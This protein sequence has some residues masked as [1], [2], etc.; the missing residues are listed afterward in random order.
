MQKVAILYDVS[1]AVLSTFDLDEVLSQIL[2]I[3][4]DYF[5]VENC[6]ILLLDPS[7]QKLKV[8]KEFGRTRLDLEIPMGKGIIGSAAKRKLPIYAPDVSKDARYIKTFAETRSELAIPLVVRDEVYGVLDFQSTKLDYFDTDTIDLLTLFS[9]QASI[10]LANARHYSKEQR[11]RRQLEAINAI[12]EQIS[13]TSELDDLLEKICSLIPEKFAVEHAALILREGELDE[14][15]LV[16]RAHAGRLTP[17]FASQWENTSSV[18][19]PA[20]AHASSSRCT[21]DGRAKMSRSLGD[22]SMPAWWM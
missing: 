9:T 3:A 1:Q 14:Q 11:Q 20:A 18:S 16:M 15:R 5:R 6:A 19:Y 8:R 7:D 12:A 13:K 21:S 2:M 22:L 10:A 17:I 4:K